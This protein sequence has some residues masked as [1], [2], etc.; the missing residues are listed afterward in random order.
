MVETGKTD[1][2]KG[3]ISKRGRPFDAFLLKAGNRVRWEFPPREAK[4]GGKGGPRA[5]KVFDPSKATLIGPSKAHGEEAQL[6]STPDAFVVT[7]PSG[8]DD[9]PRVVFELKKK[10]CDREITQA[11]IEQLMSEGK[12]ALLEGFVSKRGAKFA[13]HL[14]LSKTKAKADFEFPPR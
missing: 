5:K 1:L 11:E 10:L 9:T 8:A 14:V 7:K 12:T 4:P 3:F 13:A 2:I 6:Q